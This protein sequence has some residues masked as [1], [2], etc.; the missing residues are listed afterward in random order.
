MQLSEERKK[1]AE[2]RFLT[3]CRIIDEKEEEIILE[4]ESQQ[5]FDKQKETKKRLR[6]G[7]RMRESTKGI[8]KRGQ[9][10]VVD[11]QPCFCLLCFF[12]FMC[13]AGV[14]S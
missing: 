1:N 8:M 6:E 5:V 2:G 3:C 11:V 10:N 7:G 12:L 13:Q 4:I 14:C 9:G